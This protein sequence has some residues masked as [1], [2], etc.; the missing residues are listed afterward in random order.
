M[1]ISW[2]DWTATQVRTVPQQVAA[3]GASWVLV[4]P[5]FWSVVEPTRGVSYN[6]SGYDAALA[7]PSAA[8]LQALGLIAMNPEWARQDQGQASGPIR[9]DAIEAFVAFARS[10]VAR[11][12]RPPYNIKTWMLYAEVDCWDPAKCGAYGHWGDHPDRYAAMLARVYPELKAVSD[13]VRV[14]MGSVALVTNASAPYRPDFFRG[15]M[16]AGA[17]QH[18]DAVGFNYFPVQAD[19]WKQYGRDILGKVNYLR[20]IMAQYQGAE[21]KDVICT[22]VLA[23]GPEQDPAKLNAQAMYLPKV[24]ARAYSA[25]V[26]MLM[27]LGVAEWDERSGVGLLDKSGQ[28]KPAWYAYQ[29]FAA[30]M[31][32][33]RPV[34]A[35]NDPGGELRTSTSDLEGYRFARAEPG[36]EVWILW[37]DATTST[38]VVSAKEAVL[39]DKQGQVLPIT[40][41]GPTTF[42]FVLSPEP[43]YLELLR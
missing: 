32:D 39:R 12:S 11:Y 8:G 34:G 35:V 22:E 41:T 42:E 33:T 27:Y 13:D 7:A 21:S 28:P 26:A 36:R 43:V 9:D 29:Y 15:A 16:A 25:R 4:K 38:A 24:Y 31:Q 14:V 30:T 18:V 2:Y 17:W 1:G 3:L 6:W 23:E 19:E 40:P 20:G 37:T 10:A 5:I